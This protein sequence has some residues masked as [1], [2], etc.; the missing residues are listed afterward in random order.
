MDRTI[1][2]LALGAVATGCPY[3]PKTVDP[4]EIT[5]NDTDGSSS[6]TDVTVSGPSDSTS[7][8]SPTSPT[9]A[10]TS[11]TD[12]PEGCGDGQVNGDEVCDDGVNDGSYGGCAVDCSALGPHCGDGE[13]NGDEICDDG[14]NDDSYGG[15]SADCSALGPHCGDSEVNG[16]EDCDN[17]DANANGSGCNVDCITSGK[18]VG[19]YMRDMLHF[20]E[21]AYLTRPAFRDNGKTVVAASGVCGNDSRAL[22]ELNPDVTESDSYDDLLLS[23]QPRQ[24]MTIGD[25]WVL[26]GYEC[27]WVISAMGDLSEVCEPMRVAGVQ[28]L[29][30][31]D[32]G[33]Y[34]ALDYNMLGYFPDGSPMLGDAPVWT[35][36]PMNDMYYTYYFYAAPFGSS[37]S[38]AV[39]GQQYYSGDSSYMAW[40]ARYT[41]GGNLANQ[42][43]YSDYDGFYDAVAAPD[44]TLL[45]LSSSPQYEA[46]KLDAT[47]QIESTFATGAD[48]NI[49]AAYDSTGAYVLLFH[50]MAS[51][52]FRMLKR[53]S[54]GT[55]LWDQLL[56]GIDWNSR[57]AIDDNDGI[58]VANAGG[59]G[60]AGYLLVE[61]FA[62]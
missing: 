55:T 27:N 22:I 62:P 39:V 38:V 32:N 26:S 58:W 34:V 5:T 30:A 43:W 23:E 56:P 14:T 19:M 47:Y 15:C 61:K 40:I 7:P 6:A 50:D 49:T 44:G 45:V 29:E 52:S 12:I 24:A 1:R 8:T 41:A 3:D 54:D 2:L 57:L 31:G 46:V 37:G 59:F 16:P 48:G 53:S 28:A 60:D 18:Q 35:A 13:M 4:T 20:C 25:D 51:Q 36:A 42:Y 17:G 11:A 21:G 9:E 33:V 10:D